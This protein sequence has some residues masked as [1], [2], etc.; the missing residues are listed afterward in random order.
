MEMKLLQHFQNFVFM[1]VITFIFKLIVIFNNN[2]NK[3][4]EILYLVI[5]ATTI[6]FNGLFI[7]LYVLIIVVIFNLIINENDIVV[8]HYVYDITYQLKVVYYNNSGS[9]WNYNTSLNKIVFL[10]QM[11]IYFIY[12]IY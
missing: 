1:L 3:F 4:N 8:Y 2:K 5:T 12:G 11:L 10:Q 7:S 9:V 6:P